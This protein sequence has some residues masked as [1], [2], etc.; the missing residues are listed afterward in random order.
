[1]HKRN[2]IRH[3]A[4]GLP[5]VAAL[6]LLAAGQGQAG[7]LQLRLAR[8]G[9]RVDLAA[10]LFKVRSW[11][12]FV[13]VSYAAAAPQ[14]TDLVSGQTQL[15]FDEV[16]SGMPFAKE[17]RIKLIVVAAKS[18]TKAFPQVPALGEMLPGYDAP[19]WLGIVAPKGT[20][21][22]VLDKLE[23]AFQEALADKEVRI[24]LDGQGLDA[25]PMNARAFGDKIRREMALWEEA[26]KASGMQ[27]T[28]AK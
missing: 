11:L 10:E 12:N 25:D 2:F 18:R 23:A 8:R 27:P 4:C 15:A 7:R 26:V 1:M 16:S 24:I 5:G 3:I 20:L 14:M 28:T 13:H 22:D 19:A 9:H 6:P 17:G 21:Q